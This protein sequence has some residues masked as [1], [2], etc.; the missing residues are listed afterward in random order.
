MGFL[1]EVIAT[2]TSGY[3][4]VQ[5]V[6]KNRFLLYVSTSPKRAH[7]FLSLPTSFS[8]SVIAY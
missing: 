8:F 7:L 2:A 4:R 6:L 1:S 5:G 3:D